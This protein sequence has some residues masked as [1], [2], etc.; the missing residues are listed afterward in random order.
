MKPSYQQVIFLPVLAV[1]VVLTIAF[2]G[3][4]TSGLL[5]QSPHPAVAVGAKEVVDAAT[6]A[7]EQSSV[8]SQAPD[9]PKSAEG[10]PLTVER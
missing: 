8:S 2:F 4:Y 5:R 6:P 3:M 9:L 7:E 10:R 1:L